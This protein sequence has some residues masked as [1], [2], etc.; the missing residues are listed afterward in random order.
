MKDLQ[1]VI[2]QNKGGYRIVKTYTAT[3]IKGEH[4]LALIALRNAMFRYGLRITELE[5]H[6][7]CNQVDIRRAY[8]FTFQLNDVLYDEHYV[9]KFLWYTH[10]VKVECYPSGLMYVYLDGNIMP[11]SRV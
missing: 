3:E 1:K 2:N 5:P 11:S 4:E 8:D 6:T 10:T 7:V 9:L